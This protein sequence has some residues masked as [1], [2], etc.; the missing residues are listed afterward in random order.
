[1]TKHVK[2][3]MKVAGEYRPRPTMRR[4]TLP[5]GA[6]IAYSA[7]VD[8][9]QVLAMLAEKTA[10]ANRRIGMR[11]AS[12]I[13]FSSLPRFRVVNFP[14]LLVYARQVVRWA[15]AVATTDEPRPGFADGT[16]KQLLPVEHD[17]PVPAKEKR[18]AGLCNVHFPLMCCHHVSPDGVLCFRSLVMLIAGRLGT[19]AQ[20]E[21]D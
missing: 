18:L 6:V 9:E 2:K 13:A 7:E 15:D 3:N 8:Q 5:S 10:E 4:R 11:L 19:A 16:G 14:E 20:L 12:M 17:G 1:M 21:T